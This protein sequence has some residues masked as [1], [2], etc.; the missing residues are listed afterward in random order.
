MR[1]IKEH[2]LSLTMP[3]TPGGRRDNITVLVVLIKDEGHQMVKNA[4]SPALA[5][6]YGRSMILATQAYRCTT[7]TAEQSQGSQQ[8]ICLFTIVAGTFLRELMPPADSQ[9]VYSLHPL[10]PINPQRA[11]EMLKQYVE[12]IGGDVSGSLRLLTSSAL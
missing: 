12:G 8:G 2:H 11:R 4:K 1:A 7:A 10:T 9:Y 3:V 6:E 5:R